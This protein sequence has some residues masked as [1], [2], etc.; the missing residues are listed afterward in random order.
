VIQGDDEYCEKALEKAEELVKP[1]RDAVTG[2]FLLGAVYSLMQSLIEA[3][4]EKP[5]RTQA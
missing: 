1:L 5:R 2:S 4:P 3:L